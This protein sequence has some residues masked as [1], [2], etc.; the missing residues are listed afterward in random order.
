MVQ[1]KIDYKS[2]YIFDELAKS[3][4][5]GH[6]YTSIN[7]FT[8]V[9]QAPIPA[10]GTRTLTFSG[11]P[12]TSALT[13][14]AILAGGNVQKI[15]KH[16]NVWNIPLTNII[17]E[18]A[19][20]TFNDYEGRFF[21]DDNILVVLAGEFQGGGTGTAGG[22]WGSI[23]GDIDDQDDLKTALDTIKSRITTL[24]NKDEIYQ[25]WQSISTGSGSVTIPT[26][27]TITLNK[28]SGGVDAIITKIDGVPKDEPVLDTNG[29]IVSV[30]LTSTGGYTL[31]GV[32]TSYPVAIIY[33]IT[34]STVD[35]ATAI[36]S[37]YVIDRFD[38]ITSDEILIEGRGT[39]TEFGNMERMIDFSM[40]PYSIKGFDFV[41]NS[42]SISFGEGECLLRTSNADDAPLVNCYIPAT[43]IPL[44]DQYTTF[45]YCD[46]ANGTAILTSTLDAR[47]INFT[48]QTPMGVVNRIG[49]YI[50]FADAR[51]GLTNAWAKLVRKTI[52]AS[53]FEHM[54]GTSRY[55]PLDGV[56]NPGGRY[57]IS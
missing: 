53:G 41:K 23:T 24:E 31:S 5:G 9:P 42:A 32:P 51:Y 38:Y 47:T 45:I 56:G 4:Q 22:T 25:I 2:V 27:G 16:G 36:N 35:A 18:S 44:M 26:G 19:N 55:I 43:E 28:Y 14:Q 20:A 10:T 50:A 48:T 1:N 13:V 30:T 21:S 12:G 8:V 34:I 40:S 6:L 39:V 11:L 33:F 17:V 49:D 7:D 3:L 46:Y 37:D 15:D 57:Y 29:T 54:E 52:G